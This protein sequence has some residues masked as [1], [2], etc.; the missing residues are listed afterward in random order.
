MDAVFE[1]E[2]AEPCLAVYFRRLQVKW[3]QSKGKSLL[4]RGH[5]LRS[6]FFTLRFFE[7]GT[8]IDKPSLPLFRQ[9]LLLLF[10]DHLADRVLSIFVDM[11]TVTIEFFLCYFVDV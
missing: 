11:F 8:L 4:E 10:D 2:A 7:V 9:L 1:L 6:Q 3:G 5:F